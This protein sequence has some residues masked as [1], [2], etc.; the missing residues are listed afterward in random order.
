MDIKTD[1]KAPKPA[2][3]SAEP[4]PRRAYL[5]AE[6]RRRQILDAAREVFSQTSL[7]GARTRDLARAAGVNQA[8]IY[9]HFESKEA[10]FAE[11]VIEPLLEVMRG[12]HERAGS[13]REA[14]TPEELLSLTEASCRRH[15][16][17][18]EAIYPLLASALFAD[19]KQGRELY[20]EHLA[21]LFQQRGEAMSSVVRE[22]IPP[23]FFS[24]AAFGMFFAVAMHRT[25]SDDVTPLEEQAE[26]LAKLAAF[27]FASF[28]EKNQQ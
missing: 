2:D 22:D 12:M 4:R 19:P 3:T 13:Y 11:A 20:R 15:L 5:P 14:T 1:K 8:T 18:M 17:N 21:P 10:L 6:E 25:F 9:G 24:L 16:E 26:Q 28:P 23:D 7:Q 27:G